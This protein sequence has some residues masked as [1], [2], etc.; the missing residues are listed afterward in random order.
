M[1][2]ACG[3]RDETWINPDIKHVFQ[4]LHD[5]KQAHSVEIYNDQDELIGGL[6]GLSIGGC[7]CGESMFS[8]SDNASK[9]ALVALAERCQ[10]LGYTMIDTQ[11]ITDHLTQFGTKTMPQNEYLRLFETIRLLHTNFA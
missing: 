5:L 6:Y 9:I 7:F 3:A 8:R 11:F 1:I 4:E 2:D 10:S